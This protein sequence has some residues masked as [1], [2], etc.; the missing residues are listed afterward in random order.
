MS[1]PSTLKPTLRT[2]RQRQG[3]AAWVVNVP[4]ALS[5][6]DRR[7]ELFFTSKV[8]AV[9]VCEQLKARRDNFGISLNALTPAKIAEAAEAYNI[10]EGLNVSLTTV[11]RDYLRAHKART[12]SVTFLTLFDQFLNAKSDRSPKYLRELRSTRNRFPDLHER[13][14]SDI[15]HLELE[16][17]LI[18]I[19]PGGRNTVMSFLRSVFN[20]GIKR[21]YLT[22]NPIARLDF[23][24]RPRCEVVTIP[25]EQVAVMLNHAFENDLDLLPFLV[26]G[27]FTGVRPSGEL[28]KLEWRDVSLTERGIPALVIRPEVSKTNRRRFVDL[29]PNAIAWIEAFRQQGRKLEGRISPFT[30]ATL[31]KCRLKN[32]EAAGIEVWPQ[33]GMRHT[34]CSNW[35]AVHKDV[36]RLVLQSG[37]DSVDTMW[38][39]YHRGTPEAEAEKFWAIMPPS[40]ASN[41]V[42][43]T[44]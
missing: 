29:S 42:R 31:R 39:H 3:I 35:L 43:M 32:W 11:A 34:F 28:Q 40:T 24:E 17:L 36:N 21:G 44:T 15:S 23:A 19:S 4:P 6:T 7:Q 27:F 10:L 25:N 12:A 13:L 14:V 1:H 5:P 8:E 18:P 38:R 2:T 37:H 33:Q 26:F 16:P 20:Y 30:P 9:V 41:V 22:E